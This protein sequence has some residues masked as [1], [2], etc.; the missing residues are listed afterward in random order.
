MPQRL[1]GCLVASLVGAAA[2]LLLPAAP[3]DADP[4]P[5]RPNPL[6]DRA[7]AVFEGRAD[8][9]H[10]TDASMVL[11]DV[12]V[13]RPTMDAAERWRAQRLLARPTDGIGDPYGDGYR[14]PSRRTCRGPICVHHVPTTR[15]APPSKAWV[16]TTLRVMNRVWR[17]EVGELGYR[18]PPRD[19]KHGGDKRFD[20]YLKDLGRQGLFGYCAPEFRV[21]GMRHVASGYCVLDNDF[22]KAQYGVAPRVSLRVTAAHEFFHAVQFGYDFREDPW[23]LESTAAWMEERVADDADDNRRYLPYGQVALPGTSL[24]RFDP[25]GYQ[26]Y[27]N[28]AFWE[29]LSERFG[30]DVV[31]DVWDEASA[32]PGAPDRYS[33][34]ALRRALA[35]RGGLKPVFARYAAALARPAASFAEG[36]AWPSAELGSGTLGP[37]KR[38]AHTS[39]RLNHL[40]SRSIVVRPGQRLRGGWRLE[41]SVDGPARAAGPAAYVQVVR[42]DGRVRGRQVPLDAEGRGLTRVRFDA[43]RVRRV[44][45]TLA[46]TSTRYRCRAGGPTYACQGV[47]RDQ[48]ARFELAARI[49]R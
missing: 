36:S 33:V 5:P 30:P 11:R 15:D 29:H 46:N 38:Y 41:L 21:R 31:R 18:R 34:A 2:L 10:R 26:Q 22:A 48:R 40:A 24:D 35:S 43:D 17:T 42:R 20:V 39:V 44:V 37:G 32:R 6:L 25:A 1:L 47:P 7:D 3:A 13:A 45:V 23:L 49:R 14:V 8:A 19:G 27:G 9:T 16:R 4:R 28:W 12:F